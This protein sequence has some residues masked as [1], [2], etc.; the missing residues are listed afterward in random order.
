M[1][2]G[3]TGVKEQTG[4]D[5]DVS[6][7]ITIDLTR[8]IDFVIYAVIGMVILAMIGV[9]RVATKGKKKYTLSSQLHKSKK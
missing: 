9:I 5:T 1:K 7:I 6:T 3:I 4:V 2:S 8:N